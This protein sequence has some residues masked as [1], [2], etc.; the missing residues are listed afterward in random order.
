MAKSHVKIEKRIKLAVG[1]LLDE[2]IKHDG[3]FAA[4]LGTKGSLRVVI[5]SSFLYRDKRLVKTRQSPRRLLV[6]LA[7]RKSGANVSAISVLDGQDQKLHY[8]IVSSPSSSDEVK[9]ADAVTEEI[10]ELGDVLFVLIGRIKGLRKT[11]CTVDG[12]V[13]KLLRLDTKQKKEIHKSGQEYTIASILSIEDLF[14]NV[15]TLA[16]SGP[17]AGKERQ[18]IAKAY[19]E[20]LEKVT[21]DVCFPNTKI[22]ELDQTILGKIAAALREQADQYE[23]AVDELKKHPDNRQALNEV[24]RIAYNFST[25]VLPLM[26]LLVGICDVKP[27]VFWCTA[28]SHW[29]LYRAFAS[30]P[31][32]ALGR[33]ENIPDYRE[34]IAAARNQ[35]FHHILPFETTVE[36]DLTN[37]DVRAETIRLFPPFSRKDHGGVRL[38]DQEI[39]DLFSEFSRAKQRPVSMKFWQG[40]LNVMEAT[41]TLVKAALEA[42]MDINSVRGKDGKK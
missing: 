32:S 27:L 10:K 42:L 8:R 7:N 35:A 4:A 25:D 24:L 41:Y 40:N 23:T 17:L 6:D 21:I 29:L 3:S 14:D 30:L 26:F 16:G 1:K 19:D 22:K 36:V 38:K 9:L 13:V 37:T 18:I 39:V 31:W 11:E 12:D 20:L 33:K 15:E 2:V 5:N 34:I 28:D